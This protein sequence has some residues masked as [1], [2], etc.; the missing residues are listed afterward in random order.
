MGEDFWHFYLKLQNGW[1]W[2]FQKFNSNK[3]EVAS[4]IREN[5]FSITLGNRYSRVTAGT[6]VYENSRV[7]HRGKI[8]HGKCHLPCCVLPHL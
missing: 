3:G 1:H 7:M 5:W 8:Y 2:K 4:T 6:T